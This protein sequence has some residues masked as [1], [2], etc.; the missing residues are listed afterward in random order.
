MT[1]GRFRCAESEFEVKNLNIR[2]Q[3]SKFS[4]KFYPLK[5]PLKFQLPDFSLLVR[6]G[7]IKPFKGY[8]GPMV[9]PPAS[10]GAM[11]TPLPRWHWSHDRA[12]R[13]PRRA[14]PPPS[15]TPFWAFIRPKT[16]L[17]SKIFKY[18]E[19]SCCSRCV[20]VFLCFVY[21]FVGF[22]ML[23][24]ILLVLF[25][26]VGLVWSSPRSGL[27]PETLVPPTPGPF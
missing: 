11:Q 1:P 24:M 18:N 16:W 27:M 17:T 20:L 22:D 8:R 14:H 7:P 5:F 10:A 19:K 25:F 2:D 6:L 4:E 3:M 12:C 15:K 26:F 23:L 13:R 9:C 21:V